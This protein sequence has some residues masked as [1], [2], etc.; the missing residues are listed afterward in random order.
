MLKLAR[1]LKKYK[2]QVII[3]PFFKWLEAVFE[4]I[5]PFVMAKII[6]VGIAGNNLP[7]IYKMGAVMIAL[8]ISGYGFSLICQ[9]LATKTA[10]G[11]GQ[12]LRRDLYHKINTF[13]YSDLDRFGAPTLVTRITN[14]VQ[15]LSWAVA[16]LIRLV[17]RAPFLIIG[18][19]IMSM[20][21][22]IK[23]SII[24]I[25]GAV[26]VSIIYYLIMTK[27]VPYFKNIQLK[28]DKI[29]LLTRENLSG[30]RVVRAFSKQ[31]D[32]IT[33]FNKANTEHADLSIKAGKI[34]SLLNPLTYALFNIA[35][36]AIIWFGGKQVNIGN[37]TQGEVI[38]LINYM[39]QISIALI[40]VAQL[41][42]TFTRASASAIRVNEIFDVETSKTE[43]INTNLNLKQ[44]NNNVKVSFKDVSFMYHGNIAPSLTNFSLDVYDGETVGII[45]GTGSGKTTLVNLMP[46]FYDVTQ[47]NIFIDGINVK[48]YSADILRNKFGIVSQHST[49]FKGSIK[50]NLLW[51]NKNASLDEINYAL[52]VSE[53]K[54]FVDRKANGIDYQITQNGKNLSGGQ[55]QRL[56]IARAIIKK[57]EILILDDSFSALDFQTD[58]K[59][60]QNIKNNLNNATVFIVS[61]R[62]NTI[63]NA[64]KIV[65]LD[66]GKVAGIGTHNQLLDSCPLYKKICDL[67]T[68]EVTDEN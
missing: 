32:E 43:A 1:Y 59:L 66:S 51:G 35:I 14:D 58:L 55:R 38:A 13:S 49:L 19:T 54:E 5:V 22:N 40:I 23:I 15:Q 6:D 7:Y 36:V 31:S 27:S 28:L 34:S 41:V 33:E 24:F 57:P 20:I 50:D 65:V 46:R 68:Y 67:Q 11:V 4:L 37:L 3:G 62:I 18:A 29:S 39:T 56:C 9:T 44:L 48:D 64:D 12:D 8:G 17:V 30:T 16:M 45:G 47:G 25:F 61:Q 42:I 52:T 26:I 10:Q 63:R 60:R 2:T 53:A 21:I